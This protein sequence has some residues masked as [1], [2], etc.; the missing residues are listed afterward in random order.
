MMALYVSKKNP[1]YKETLAWYMDA[2]EPY[3]DVSTKSF[4]NIKVEGDTVS[5]E[6]TI[7]NNGTED[8]RY[9][10]LQKI[11]GRYKILEFNY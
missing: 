6:V 4:D 10:K 5:F 11:N 2:K 3:Q 7:N 1:A 9:Y 8:W